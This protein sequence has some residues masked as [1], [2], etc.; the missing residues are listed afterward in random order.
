[1]NQP[2]GLSF[3]AYS[4][5]RQTKLLLAAIAVI[6][7][8]AGLLVAPV[9]TRPAVAYPAATVDLAGHGFGHGR[10][11][12]QYG[13]LGYALAG[14]PHTQILDHFYGGTRMGPV[15]DIPM[16][17]RILRLDNKE[18]IVVQERGLATANG[19]AP[20]PAMRVRLVAPNT[21][22]VTS[23]PGCAG[24]WT[25]V[26]PVSP[27][28]I[29]LASAAPPSDDRS[30]MLQLCEG[31]VTR[32]YRGDFAVVDSGGARTVNRLPM[33][34][35]LRGV[36]PR[37][38]PSSWGALGDGKGMNALR[39]QAVAARSYSFAENRYPFAKTCDTGACQVYG[40]FA[41]QDA[42]GFRDLE[43]GPTNAA[44]AETAGQ[45]R[46]SGTG[47]VVAT[48]FS[49]STGGHS[50]GGVFP[51][52][53]DDGDAVSLNPN[54]NWTA[55]V[56]VA[57]IEAAYPNIGALRAVNVTKRNGL[58]DFGGR[59]LELVLAGANGDQVLR[60]SEFRVKFGLKSDWFNVT[61]NASGGT[62][63]YWVVAADGGIFAFGEARFFGST[64]NLRLN[65]P[66]LGMAPT[67][68]GNGYWLVAADG[69][70]FSFGDARFAGSTGNL[71]LN[72][73]V[74]GMAATP[75]GNGYWLVARDGGI[76]AF[77]DAGFFGSTGSIRLNQPVVGMAPSPTG[78]GY[79]LVA[80][81]GGIFAFGDARFLGSTGAIR[82]NQPVIDMAAKPTGNGYWLVAAD[83][84]IF[85][86]GDSGFFGSLPG[87]SI[88]ATAR[89]IES[90]GSGGG[91]LIATEAGKVIPFGDAPYFGDVLGAI[92]G[93]RGGVRG[94][95]TR[96]TR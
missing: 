22:E 93:Y 50:A 87:R 35:Y 76:F 46:V 9:A 13:A 79:W 82:L 53:V 44:I 17:V 63:G 86:F 73:P 55:Q 81:D 58:G 21:F 34:A 67:P 32:W 29:V 36:V 64:G 19:S 80:S 75:T 91:Y 68:A 12:G 69:G 83:G 66:V 61:N 57:A 74:V 72:Q 65:A 6:S 25:P 26:A 47:A 89:G 49:S 10:G 54:H 39:A 1:M 37:E 2:A 90:T 5:R 31:P 28:P 16:S 45:V 42:A 3:S 78:K 92:P 48:E 51:A 24:P 84:G 18:T 96:S 85:A 62:S 15:G 7:V 38:S 43:A 59:V 41:V 88:T 94:L 60:G 11:M 14:W 30:S 52:V 40:G 20:S 70:I 4:L 56:P 23:G 95:A 77:G 71:R 8:T 27:G 33:E